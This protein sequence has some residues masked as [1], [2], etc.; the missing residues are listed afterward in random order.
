MRKP[1]EGWT[2]LAVRTLDGHLR[3][4][5]VFMYFT[6]HAYSPFL[7]SMIDQQNEVGRMS[8]CPLLIDQ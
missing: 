6:L 5:F 7:N 8:L 3:V 2:V 4:P 1:Q